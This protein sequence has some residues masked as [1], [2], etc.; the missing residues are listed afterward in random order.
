MGN[1]KSTFLT[2]LYFTRS[3]K[4]NQS[5]SKQCRIL[6]TIK[7]SYMFNEIIVYSQDR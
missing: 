6:N 2:P 4:I 3:D 5:S 1:R 7:I